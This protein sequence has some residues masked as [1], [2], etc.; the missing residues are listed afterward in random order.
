[1]LQIS[2]G[3]GIIDHKRIDQIN[4]LQ[5]T[6]EG[7]TKAVDALSLKPDYL[8][9]DGNKV[10]PQLQSKY[11]N[12]AEA[13]VKGDARCYLIAAAS[14]I[15]KVTRD[16]IM[17]AYHEQWPQ[18]NFIQHKGY[19]T[20]SHVAAVLNHGPCPIHRMT[21]APLKTLNL[22]KKKICGTD[23]DRSADPNQVVATESKD[24]QKTRSSAKSKSST[25]KIDSV[26]RVS[27]ADQSGLETVALKSEGLTE[28]AQTRRQTRSSKQKNDKQQSDHIPA[29]TTPVITES[30]LTASHSKRTRENVSINTDVKRKKATKKQMID[31]L[32]YMPMLPQTSC[33]FFGHLPVSTT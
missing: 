26:N 30:P 15:A 8:L 12:A 22:S 1:L 21:F 11:P 14:I 24:K 27:L 3:V 23:S 6:F 2:F 20:A 13:I 28:V 31:K 17:S 29:H 16:K 9:I 4:I 18:F 25:S 33:T 10:P 5:A 32:K 7:M 19:P